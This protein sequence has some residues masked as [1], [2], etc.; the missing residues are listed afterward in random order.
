MSTLPSGKSYAH[1][2]IYMSDKNHGIYLM[3]DADSIY[4]QEEK[5]RGE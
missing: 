1:N 2:V 4:Q 5:P 3:R